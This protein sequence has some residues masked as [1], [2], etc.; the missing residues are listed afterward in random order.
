[1]ND[2]SH[3]LAQEQ[4]AFL[5]K[6][7]SQRNEAVQEAREA[8]L[9]YQDRLGLISPQHSAESRAAVIARLEGQ[10]VDLRAQRSAQLGYLS[11]GAP[12]VVEL[13]LRIKAVEE[14]IDKEQ[15]RLASSGGATLNR[16]VEEFQRLQLTADFAMEIYK[17]ALVALEKGRIEATRTLKKVS[18]LQAP[19]LPESS[20]EPRRLYRIV[21]FV[22]SAMLLAGIVHLIAAIIR[23]H[24]D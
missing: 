11:P 1:M 16:A 13:D 7:V 2:L 17:T 12:A 22:L 9:T 5:E 21:V 10:L 24:K 18:V 15:A 23:D 8:L 6:Q 14:Q 20:E 3:Q 4:V 19:T